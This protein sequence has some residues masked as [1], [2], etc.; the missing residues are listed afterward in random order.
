MNLQLQKHAQLNK[1]T[2]HLPIYRSIRVFPHTQHIRNLVLVQTDDE[3]WTYFEIV[4]VLDEPFH[5]QGQCLVDSDG[6]SSIFCH[7][8]H[9]LVVDNHVVSFYLD[10]EVISS[11]VRCSEFVTSGS[12]CHFTMIVGV[13][14]KRHHV[15]TAFDVSILEEL[16]WF[17]VNITSTHAFYLSLE[18]KTPLG[19][20]LS[21][22]SNILCDRANRWDRHT[23]QTHTPTR[24][25]ENQG[26]RQSILEALGLIVWELLSIC[27]TS[28]HHVKRRVWH[29]SFFNSLVATQLLYLSGQPFHFTNAWPFLSFK[30]LFHAKQSIVVHVHFL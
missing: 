2:I 12:K 19:Q 23:A 16:V 24:F 3:I 18:P 1:I 13:C 9:V 29:H 10:I 6:C 22:I 28:Q 8:K 11:P 26:K 27:S 5:L 14:E 25:S 30:H 15:H 17:D 21:H 7:S 20:I 4:L